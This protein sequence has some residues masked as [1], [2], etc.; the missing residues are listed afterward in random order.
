[1]NEKNDQKFCLF[2]IRY[3]YTIAFDISFTLQV[4]PKLPPPPATQLH[5]MFASELSQICRVCHCT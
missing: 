4:I 2:I 5:I 1:M 3:R